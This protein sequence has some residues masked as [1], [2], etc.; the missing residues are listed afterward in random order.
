MAFD[1][2][3]ILISLIIGLA[4]AN[5]L[6]GFANLIH[7]RERVRLFLPSVVWAI[8]IFV[9]A[10]QH[11]WADYNAH[12]VV[13]WSF[14]AFFSML[15]IPLDLYLLSELALPRRQSAD[16]LIN[17]EAWYF[18]N[19]RW[20]FGLVAALV[21]LSFLEEQLVRGNLHKPVG[22]T[23]SLAV[24]FITALVAFL[25]RKRRIHYLIAIVTALLSAI[26]I[27]LLFAWLPQ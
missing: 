11:W 17:L 7:E 21:P 8:W 16:A 10:V 20:F 19:R 9:A 23:V 25:A 14:A 4:L 12:T 18:R 27:A 26:Y 15:L 1:Y 3:T 22:D 6:T 2:L 13:R 5:V 24:L